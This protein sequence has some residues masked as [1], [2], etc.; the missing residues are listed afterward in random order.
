MHFKYTVQQKFHKGQWAIL[1]MATL[2]IA[3]KPKSAERIAH[4][5]SDG[6][7]EK[8]SQNKA[9]WYVFQRNHEQFYVVPAVGHIYGLQQASKGFTYPVFDVEWVETFK[10]DKSANYAKKFYNNLQRLAKK[11]DSFVIA[12]DYDTEGEIIGYNVLRFICGQSTA[13]RMKFSTLTDNELQQSYEQRMAQLDQ[14]LVDAGLV[15]HF[16]DWFWGVNTS[17][18]LMAAVKQN[19]RFSILS[20]GRVQGPTLAVLA[21]REREIQAFEPQPYWQLYADTNDFTAVHTEQRIFEKARAQ[22]IYDASQQN[23]AE[24]TGVKQQQKQVKPPTPFNLTDLQREASRALKLSPSRTLQM[25]QNLYL[26]GLISYPRTSSQKLPASLGY[27]HILQDLQKRCGYGDYVKHLNLEQLQPREGKKSDPAHPAIYPTGQRPGKLEQDAYRLYDLIVKRFLATFGQP[28]Q[29]EATKAHLDINGHEFLAEGIRTVKS[30]WTALYAP[31]TSLKEQPLPQLT[32]G[33]AVSIQQVRMEEKETEPPKRYTQSSIITELEKRG[34]GTKATRSDI[35]ESLYHRQYIRDTPIQVTQL[36][37]EIIKTLETYSPAIISEELTRQFEQDMESVMEQKKKK[38]IV[39]EEAQEQLKAIMQQ[40][41]ENEAAIGEQIIAALD[42]T[43]R[44]ERYVGVC[45]DCDNELRIITAKQ[46]KK[47][48]VGCTG[49]SDGC[50]RSY[51]LPQTGMAKPT[52]DTCNE[53]GD[54]TVKIIRK[55]KRPWELCIS[56]E[57]PSKEEWNKKQ[58]KQKQTKTSQSKKKH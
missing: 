11:C 40:F 37:M 22:Q 58:Q 25:A 52:Q 29:R 42:E 32:E 33:N 38:D 24:V 35:I 57:C 23:N 27:K 44:N 34:L 3:E 41:Q 7:Y 26:A 17:R 21:E 8:E 1:H 18:A 49:Y 20:I 12:C 50:R 2:V 51:P 54:P 46:S 13:A 9:P 19:N 16:L 47:R 5:L 31:Y 48:F 10:K 30:G 36:G 56:T 55:G 14:G 53:C 6:R 28:C 43:R 39:L 15:R 45:P 4:A